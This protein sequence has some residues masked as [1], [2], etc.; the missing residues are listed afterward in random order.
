MS[1]AK[2]PWSILD[3]GIAT[4]QENMDLD[5]HLLNT[6]SD[7]PIL[8]FYDWAK[9]SA[10]YGYFIQPDQYFHLKI[11]EQR[12]QIAKRPTGGGIIFHTCDFAFSLLIPSTHSAYFLNTLQSYTYINTKVGEAIQKFLP[13]QTPTLLQKESPTSNTYKNFCMAHPTQYDILLEGRKIG[14]AAQRKTKKG[15][16]HQGS[17]ALTVPTEEFLTEILKNGDIISQMMESQTFPLLSSQVSQKELIKTRNQL[18]Q[19]LIECFIS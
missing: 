5:Q 10:T 1:G 4:A 14:G 11:A 17:I 18:K 16:L 3:T 6:L 15:I 9:E 19:C 12:L 2:V 13:S 7:Q 8:H